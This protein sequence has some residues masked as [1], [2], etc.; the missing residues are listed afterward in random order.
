M[1][2]GRKP[3]IKELDLK[4]EGM[5]AALGQN[6]M[7]VAQDFDRMNTILLATLEHLGLLKKR[8]CPECG[9]SINQ[10]VLSTLKVDYHC[11]NP[12]CDCE[13]ITVG[14]LGNQ[15]TIEDWDNGADGEE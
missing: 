6:F 10:P 13:D 11:P 14:Q 1:P 3:T 4:I 9:C 8:I 12:D 15:Q 7:L 5:N 2:K